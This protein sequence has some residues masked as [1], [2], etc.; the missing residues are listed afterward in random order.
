MFEALPYETYVALLAAGECFND[1]VPRFCSALY[2]TEPKTLETP[3][4]ANPVAGTCPA[5]PDS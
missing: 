1:I 2:T 4:T 3:G 5:V